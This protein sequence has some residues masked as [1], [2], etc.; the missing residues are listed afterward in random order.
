MKNSINLQVEK[1]TDGYVVGNEHKIK[2][3][4]CKI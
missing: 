2:I 1:I 4:Q 3:T